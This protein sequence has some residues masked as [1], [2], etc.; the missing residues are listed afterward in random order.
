MNDLRT[1]GGKSL[2]K[3]N[4]TTKEV[5]KNADLHHIEWFYSR[6]KGIIFSTDYSTNVIGIYAIKN[7]VDGPMSRFSTS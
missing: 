4:Q 3:N 7:V 1:S 6:R 5:T 2:N